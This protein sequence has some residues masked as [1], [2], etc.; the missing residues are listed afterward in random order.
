M[1]Q[2][3]SNTPPPAP[4]CVSSLDINSPNPLLCLVTAVGGVQLDPEQMVYVVFDVLVTTH[5][6]EHTKTTYPLFLSFR[7]SV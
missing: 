6:H 5:R 2:K 1:Q 3:E 7:P 4:P